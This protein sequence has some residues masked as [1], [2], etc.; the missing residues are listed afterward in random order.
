[1]VE[2]LYHAA[3][4]RI[5]KILEEPPEKTLFIL[6][7]DN[8]DQ[9][10]KTILSRTQ[11]VKFPFIA[12]DDLTDALLDEGYDQS[13][14]I[15]SLKISKGSYIEAKNLLEQSEVININTSWFTKWMRLCFG[16]KMQEILDFV[17]ELSK[18]SRDNQKAFLKY[19]LRMVRESMLLNNESSDLARL[20]KSESDFIIGTPTKRFYPFINAKNIK[21]ITDELEA[22]I[23][24]IERNANP[25]ILFFDLSLK[26][27][28][29]LKS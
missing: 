22:S 1:M 4:P 24:H 26:L 17:S 28:S 16:G 29:L 6:V 3:A 10:I 23:Y 2:K 5:L 12:I 19:A 18:Q 8:Q 15:D 25:N 9:I 11:I 13:Q 21:S 7:S 20:N 27:G 14:I